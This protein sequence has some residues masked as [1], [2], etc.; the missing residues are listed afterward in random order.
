MSDLDLSSLDKIVLTGVSAKGYHGVLPKERQ[1]GQTFVV[2]LALYQHLRV[3]AHTDDLR[4]TADY[5]AIATKIVSCIEGE[6]YQLIETLA[7]HIADEVL[8]MS[9]ASAVE[10]TVNKPQAP[11]PVQF[12]NVSVTILRWR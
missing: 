2:D 6:P 5:S 9:Q 1:H 7:Q 11:I 12:A 8:K 4:S 3:A 10:V